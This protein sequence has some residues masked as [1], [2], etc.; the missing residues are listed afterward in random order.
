MPFVRTFVAVE[1]PSEVQVAA[2]K[3]I[4]SLKDTPA[5]VRWVEPHT[6]HWTLQFLGDVDLRDVPAVCDQVAKAVAPLAPFDVAAHGVGAFPDVNRPRTL[7]IG[8]QEGTEEMVV[9][10]DAL[11]AAL[12]QIGFRAEARRYRPHL[13]IG[14]VRG[15]AGMEDLAARLAEHADLD[16]GL[17][18][19][20]EVVVLSSELTRQGPVYEQLGHGDLLG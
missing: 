3:V 11:G 20:S 9:L 5:R 18:T 2:A 6:L 17:T 14:R 15:G 16:C 10:H 13:T 1:I 7:W 4:A 12:G 19:V 8:M